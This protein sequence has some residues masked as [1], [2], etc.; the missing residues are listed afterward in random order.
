MIT[1]VVYR[2]RPG[3]PAVKA[4]ALTGADA[5]GYE[6]AVVMTHRTI[7][8]VSSFAIVYVEA[9]TEVD[10]VTDLLNTGYAVQMRL[11]AVELRS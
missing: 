1:D 3:R 11:L 6:H 5:P 10:V 7:L 8:P 9:G 4:V 2:S